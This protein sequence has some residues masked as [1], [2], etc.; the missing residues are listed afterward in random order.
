MPRRAR[1]SVGGICY[2]VINRGNRRAR[3]FHDDSAYTG[4]LDFMSRASEAVPMRVVGYCLMPNHFHLVLWPIDDGDMSRWMHRLMTAHARFHHRRFSSDGRIWQDR[5][6]SFPIEQDRHLLSVLRYV[7]RN[8][9]RAKMVDSAQQWRWSSLAW[10]A[11]T[12]KMALAV[13]APAAIGD[14]WLGIVN[15]PQSAAELEAIRTSVTRGRP[16]GSAKWCRNT[17]E[18]LGLQETLRPV[19]R[20]RT[21]AIENDEH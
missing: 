19:G 15:K 7:E 6:K 8:P 17:A 11:Q 5:F 2:H 13:V 1:V 4:F 16:Y 14:D 3:V 21:R 9:L 20:P 12:R 18:M 10:P